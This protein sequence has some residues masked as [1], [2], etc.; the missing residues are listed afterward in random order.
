MSKKILMVDDDADDAQ[1]FEEALLEMDPAVIF[2][3]AWDGQEALD[4]L[5]QKKIEVPHLIFLDINMPG[6]NGWE[7]LKLIKKNAF[8]K[9][10]P[11]IVYSTASLQREAD[12]A[13]D[14]GAFGF[15]SKPHDFKEVKLITKKITE[16][17]NGNFPELKEWCREWAFRNPL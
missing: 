1:I 17:L 12:I 6:M 14:L 9:H 16:Y 15:L 3:R 8:F 13:E 2:Y 10:I 5:E 4:S 11:V 7:F